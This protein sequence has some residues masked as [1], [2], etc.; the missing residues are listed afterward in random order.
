MSGGTLYPFLL[1]PIFKQKIWGGRLMEK[2]LNKSLP[3]D[4]PIGESWELSLYRND[5]TRVVNGPLAG[6]RL[7]ELFR[8]RPQELLGR[9]PA[10]GEKFPLLTKF[11]DSSQLLSLQ[12]HPPDSYAALHDGESGK[13]ECWYVVQARPSAS[14]IRGLVPGTTLE[15]FRRAIETGQE[16]EK[17]LRT[18]QVQA[19]DFI[20]M[21]AGVV[22]AIG[23]GTVILEI[24]QNSDMTYRLYDW[25]RLGGDGKPRPLHVD[26]GLEVIDFNDHSEDKIQGISYFEAGNRITHLV[27]CSYFSVELLDLESTYCL[28]TGEKSFV[29]LTLVEG[30]ATVKG[31]RGEEIKVG[32]GD[33]VLLPAKPPRS[34]VVPVRSA[35]LV[36][37]YI[38]PTHRRFMEP[39]IRRGVSME[40]IDKLIFR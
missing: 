4:I 37:A 32:P 19:G 2:L 29:V 39:L 21:P 35:R 33:T 36:K 13:T 5:V 1:A 17:M 18:Y 15:D 24:E 34:T 27:S 23:E 7:D 6:S 26:K 11:I 3:P 20:F 8:D 9:I 30:L 22:H 25:G 14:I 12:V 31:E 28:D 38:D 16:V 40:K 10:P